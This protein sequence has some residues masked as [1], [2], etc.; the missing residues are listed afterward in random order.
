VGS[1]SLRIGDKRTKTDKLVKSKEEERVFKLGPPRK[2]L[3]IISPKNISLEKGPISGEPQ[4]II[5][6]RLERSTD[7]TCE[8]SYVH[9]YDGLPR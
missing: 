5:Q 6:L 4:S 8:N 1:Y 9:V 3:W 2:C 7:F